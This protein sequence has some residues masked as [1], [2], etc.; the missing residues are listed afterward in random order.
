LCCERLQQDGAHGA[1][2]AR[3]PVEQCDAD[4]LTNTPSQPLPLTL[5]SDGPAAARHSVRAAESEQASCRSP[6]H[7]RWGS[8]A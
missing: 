2:P 7:E 4:C 1:P 5:K 3:R 6:L 8:V